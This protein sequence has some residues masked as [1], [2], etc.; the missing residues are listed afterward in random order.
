[1]VM[2]KMNKNSIIRIAAILALSSSLPTYGQA[3]PPDSGA[4]EIIEPRSL[5]MTTTR[6]SINIVG[7]AKP[8]TEAVVGGTS[9]TVYSTGLF[10]RAKNPLVVGPNK[11]V[12]EVYDSVTSQPHSK[13]LNILRNSAEPKKSIPSSPPSI[14]TSSITPSK[15]LLL[16]P[17]DDLEIS[18]K[19]VPGNIAEFQFA[20]GAYFPMDEVADPTSTEPTGL[21]RAT[22][23]AR[24]LAKSDGPN[25]GTIA[26]RLSSKSSGESE[27]TAEAKGKVEIMR[28]GT[29]RLLRVKKNIGHLSYGLTE[30]RLGGPYL[31]E[32]TS[33]TLL[34]V[35]GKNAGHY[36]VRLC[37]GLDVW[38]DED[39]VEPAPPGTP[40]PHLEFTNM[41]VNSVGD[42]DVIEIA[43]PEHIP[44]SVEAVRGA[45][46]GP[47]LDIDLYG[48]HNA[49][50][51]IT[52]RNKNRLVR[53]VTVDEPS[54]DHL[55]LHA[56]LSMKRMW[57]YR[58]DVSTNSLR[59][60][61]RKP[62]AIAAAPE[63]PLKG[64]TIAIEPGHGGSNSGAKGMT[65][66]LEKDVTRDVGLA[67]AEELTSAGAKVVIVRKGDESVELSERVKRAVDA[68]A[69]IFISIHCNSSDIS[70][71]GN[72]T[73]T[74]H[75]FSRDL[76]EAIHNRI[77]E[78]TGLNDFGNVGN[79]NYTPIRLMT[80]MPS[81]LVEQAFISNPKEEAL[82]LDPAFQRTMA[83]AIR[84]GLEDY[85]AG[86]R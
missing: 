20:G 17:D 58:V 44:Y 15:G 52:H 42:D 72:C 19:G 46:G 30:V 50:T 81:M 6:D 55:R 49:V 57:G 22:V 26:L 82:L 71:M 36:R 3:T 28:P 61:V 84:E 13:T 43:Y 76:S 21:Y 25:S 65:G 24:S 41:T 83:K 2:P 40:V 56:D 60:V 64:L 37:P 67:L 1:M 85:A 53:E 47:G 48:A 35:S 74:K 14:D 69:D 39:E 12:V 73:F 77:I 79:F 4:L 10:Y 18:F 7:R 62:P 75:P 45:G 8:G 68:N 34:R 78:R 51:W 66:A 54:N 80:W 11:I 23:L 16:Q 63:P 27:T 38:I 5:E 32:V 70:A 86:E 59:V 9:T 29:V 33:G 31:S